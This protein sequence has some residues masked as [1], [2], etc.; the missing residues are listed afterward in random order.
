MEETIVR[1][2]R[3][4][5]DVSPDVASHHDDLVCRRAAVRTHHVPMASEEG[6]LEW[7]MVRG[8]GDAPSERLRQINHPCI[9]E[10]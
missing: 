8:H 2:M 7:W 3:E 10:G 5:I 6:D 4:R 9:G 1:Y